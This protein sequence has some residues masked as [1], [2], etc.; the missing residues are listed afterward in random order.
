ME[1]GEDTEIKANRP[2]KVERHF[3]V[4]VTDFPMIM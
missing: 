4:S 1:M 3:L 2:Q